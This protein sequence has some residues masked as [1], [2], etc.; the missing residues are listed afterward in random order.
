M[1]DQRNPLEQLFF[2]P[3][4]PDFFAAQQQKQA[5]IQQATDLIAMRARAQQQAAAAR[6]PQAA[7]SPAPAKQ[8]SPIDILMSKST[9]MPAMQPGQGIISIAPSGD[10]WISANDLPDELRKANFGDGSSFAGFN[11]SAL[12][13]REQAVVARWRAIKQQQ[14]DA[15][16]AAD[17]EFQKRLAAAKAQA[18]EQ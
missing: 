7:T 15:A 1:S 4:A 3:E 10:D 16:A 17:P 5:G 14:R 6:R 9:R 2:Q 11:L 12:D 18:G 8:P 13:P